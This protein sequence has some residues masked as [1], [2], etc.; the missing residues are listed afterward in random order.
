MGM[1]PEGVTPKDHVQ[2][3]AAEYELLRFGVPI[4]PA[5]RLFESRGPGVP[6]EVLVSENYIDESEDD[7]DVDEV[8]EFFW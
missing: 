8:E 2:I 7:M 3:M 6:W 4:N 1:I 5:P